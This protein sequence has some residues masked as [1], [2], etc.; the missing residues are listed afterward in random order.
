[1]AAKNIE[2]KVGI[3]V[4]AGAA[5]LIAAIWLAKGYRFGQSFYS[6]SVVFPDVGSL[7]TGDPV[8]VSGVTEGKVE[9]VR[10]YEGGVLVTLELSRDVVLKQDATFTIKNLGLM[11]ER[12]IAVKT[13][14]SATPLDMSQPA[15]GIT[16]SGIPEVMG[17]MG[18]VIQQLNQLVEKLDQTIASPAT[19]DKFSQTITD[20]QRLSA[21]LDSATKYNAPKIDK[22][23]DNFAS[24]SDKLK[25]GVDRNEKYVDTAVQN[26]DV[27]AR[28]LVKLTDDMEEASKRFKS[29]ATDLDE[30]QGSLRLMM[31]DRRLYDDLRR[32]ALNLD[33]LV[34]DIRQNPKKYIS[35]SVE[36]F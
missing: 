5:V 34:V 25:Q 10:L 17:T 19:L 28:R 4:L 31:E 18:Q 36:L 26:I 16:E 32:A 6:V 27:A 15:K 33:S 20:L 8:S 11:G 13:G 21:R 29:F 7:S 23:V 3:L 14:K 9:S 35:F 2:I 22:T 30:S 1:M 12:F 24:L